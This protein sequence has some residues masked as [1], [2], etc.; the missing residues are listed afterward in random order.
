MVKLMK[1]L[2]GD[3]RPNAARGLPMDAEQSW[4]GNVVC[5]PGSAFG[6]DPRLPSPNVANASNSRRV[7][8]EEG[9]IDALV[10]TILVSVSEAIDDMVVP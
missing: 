1:T 3:G 6:V 4:A 8:M 2:F 9:L 7:A 5:R 10:D